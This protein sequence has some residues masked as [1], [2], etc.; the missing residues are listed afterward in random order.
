MGS[1][2]L[3]ALSSRRAEISACIRLLETRPSGRGSRALSQLIEG[4][5]RKAEWLDKRIG[6]ELQESDPLEQSRVAKIERENHAA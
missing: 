4:L 1:Q 5:R 6:L 2:S 3:L